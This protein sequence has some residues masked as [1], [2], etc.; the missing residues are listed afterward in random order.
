VACDDQEL[1]I[2]FL[3]EQFDMHIKQGADY[4]PVRFELSY[5]DGS[6][7]VLT[8]G[9][10]R[11]EIRKKGLDTGPAIAT[12]VINIVAENAFTLHLTKAQTLA[13]PA[14]E[15]ITDKASGYVHD[16]FFDAPDGGPTMPLYWGNVFC[17]RRVTK[18]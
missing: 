15:F 8:G 2:G 18:S 6:P 11:C 12:P 14:G 4:G 3:G 1:E 13:I 9:T 17:F 10:V 16:I 7:F 5:E